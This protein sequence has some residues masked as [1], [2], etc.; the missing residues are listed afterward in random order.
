MIVILDF[1]RSHQS[2]RFKVK[3]ATPEKFLELVAQAFQPVRVNEAGENARP[4]DFA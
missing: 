2:S 1:L 4:T 3:T